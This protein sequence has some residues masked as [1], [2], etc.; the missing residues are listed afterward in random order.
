MVFYAVWVYMIE[1]NIRRKW[2]LLMI[3]ESM[4]DIGVF[5]P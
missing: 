3:I 4:K 5:I 1:N 2:I